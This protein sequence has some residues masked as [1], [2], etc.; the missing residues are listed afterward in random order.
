[1]RVMAFSVLWQ[2]TRISH[3]CAPAFPMH[4]EPIHIAAWLPVVLC[5]ARRCGPYPGVQVLTPNNVMV[6]RH[7]SGVMTRPPDNSPAHR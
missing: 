2:S 6:Y 1:M 5:S 4:R 3:L 7:N